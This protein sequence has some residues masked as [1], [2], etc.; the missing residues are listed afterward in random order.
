MRRRKSGQRRGAKQDVRSLEVCEV[1]HVSLCSGICSPGFRCARLFQSSLQPWSAAHISP[2]LLSTYK[3]VSQIR[4]ARVREHKAPAT[5]DVCVCVGMPRD[6][7]ILEFQPHTLAQKT[8]TCTI[9]GSYDWQM[10]S[11]RNPNNRVE[12]DCKTLTERAGNRFEVHLCETSQDKYTDGWSCKYLTFSDLEVGGIQ[13]PHSPKSCRASLAQNRDICNLA[14]IFR[15]YRIVQRFWRY[16]I[17][18]TSLYQCFP[19]DPVS[20]CPKNEKKA[21]LFFCLLHFSDEMYSLHASK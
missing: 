21:V 8:S 7:V 6:C 11:S 12:C 9:P 20:K 5:I 2:A 14:S 1:P 10:L 15:K 17:R 13:N 4:Y 3:Y 16:Y 18:Q 19:L